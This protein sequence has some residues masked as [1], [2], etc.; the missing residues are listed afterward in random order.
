MYIVTNR[1][2]D[3]L[4]FSI[5]YY[6]HWAPPEPGAAKHALLND[7]LRSHF[8]G[9]S[10]LETTMQDLRYAMRGLRR[11]PGL[12]IL[13]TATLSIGIAASTVVFS[14]FQAALLKPLP[15]SQADRVV[16]LWETRQDRGITRPPSP[17]PTSG[18]SVLKTVRLRRS[19]PFTTMKP[20]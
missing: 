3:E 12:A 5:R 13:A 17:K 4:P 6:K 8:G 20:I 14:I 7:E 15:F 1:K 10:G 9:V 18:M 19:R 2:C 11:N 16:Q